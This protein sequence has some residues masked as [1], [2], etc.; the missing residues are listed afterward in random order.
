[1]KITATI[2][3]RMSSSRLPGKVLKKICGKPII[4]WQIDR[5]N[6]SILIDE[7]DNIWTYFSLLYVI[8]T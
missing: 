7:T 4:E 3:A 5:I 6:K 2:Q 1:M 8:I